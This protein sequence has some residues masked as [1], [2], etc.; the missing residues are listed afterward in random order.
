[1]RVSN[2]L[3]YVFNIFKVSIIS[4]HGNWYDES[5]LLQYTIHCVPYSVVYAGFFQG[6]GGVESDTFVSTPGLKKVAE[7]GGGGG[8][9]LFFFP[10]SKFVCQFCLSIFLTRPHRT[11]NLSDKSKNRR[12]F[13]GAGVG[14]GEGFQKKKIFLNQIKGSKFFIGSIFQTQSISVFWVNRHPI[15][16]KHTNPLKGKSCLSVVGT[17]RLDNALNLWVTVVIF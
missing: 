7:G 15:H 5:L 6:G 4:V 14:G 10:S 1:M 13:L 9:T 17:E 2:Q 11:S 16:Q 3:L 8:R 12:L